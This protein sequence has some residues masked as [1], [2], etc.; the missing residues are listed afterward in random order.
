MT[1]PMRTSLLHLLLLL[2]TATLVGL[3]SLIVYALVMSNTS[4]QSLRTGLTAR[5]VSPLVARIHNYQ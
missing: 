3:V 4:Q 5:L 2:M 1:Q